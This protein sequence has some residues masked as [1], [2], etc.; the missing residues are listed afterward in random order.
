MI[1]E[2]GGAAMHSGLQ[3]RGLPG[4]PR[5]ALAEAAPARRCAPSDPLHTPR[6][7]IVALENTHNSSGGGVWPLEA[8]RGVVE[9]RARARAR[10]PPRRRAARERRR[11]VGRAGRGDRRHVRHGHALPLEGPRLPARRGDRGLGRA[12]GAGA[13]R[14]APL[15]RRDAA[16]RD[17]RGGRASTRS[18][19]TSSGSPTTTRARCGSPR[20][21]PSAACPPTRSSS[22]RTS[23][24]STSATLE[25]TSAE[26]I[27]AARR[28]RRRPERTVE[29]GVLR[30]VTHL[31][32]TRRGRRARDRARPARARHRRLGLTCCRRPLRLGRDARATSSGTTSCSRPGTR[33]GSRRSGAGRRRTSSREQFRAER[34]PALLADGAAESARLRRRAPRAARRRR[35]TT[36]ST[37]SST[38]STRRGARRARSS[39]ARTRCSRRCTTASCASRSSPTHW[40]EPARLVRRELRGARRHGARRPHRA[41]GRGRRAQAVAA[42]SSRCALAQLGARPARGALRRRP[43]VDDVAGAAGVGMSTAQ[44]LWFRADEARRGRAGLPRLHAG[45]RADRREAARRLTARPGRPPFVLAGRAVFGPVATPEP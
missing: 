12:D 20:A 21:G 22:R 33:R 9:T 8:L 16:G 3:T 36:S 30:A 10:R 29:P 6:A 19:T 27:A 40:P 26:A 23:C 42:R 14:E 4:L 1:S 38:P 5:R 11:R 35:A 32:I 13:G 31:D 15:R 34:L 39:T 43:P 18:S 2:L 25:L 41:L 28:G 17:R 45:R 37:A 24:R 7:S 44:A